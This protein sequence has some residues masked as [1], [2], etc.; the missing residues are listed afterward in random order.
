M[1]GISISSYIKNVLDNP[2]ELEEIKQVVGEQLKK[3]ENQKKLIALATE[4]FNDY[5]SDETRAQELIDILDKAVRKTK[6]VKYL[7]GTVNE[8]KLI[9]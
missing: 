3:P 7:Y 2:K 4:L 5:V 8:N 6:I 9:K 1:W